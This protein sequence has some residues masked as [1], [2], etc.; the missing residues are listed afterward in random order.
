MNCFVVLN[1]HS[2]TYSGQL[3]YAEG[4][5]ALVFLHLH[6]LLQNFFSN[7]FLPAMQAAAKSTVVNGRHP[8]IEKT[9]LASMPHNPWYNAAPTFH[10]NWRGLLMSSCGPGVTQEEGFMNL[11]NLLH[12]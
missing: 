1:I 7:T 10:G 5:S 8:C 11:I 9:T 6:S 4:V 2:N 12:K 3:Q